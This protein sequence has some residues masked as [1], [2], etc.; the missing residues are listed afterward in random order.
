MIR[1]PETSCKAGPVAGL[2][3]SDDGMRERAT[4]V[5]VAPPPQQAT[6]QACERE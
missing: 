3:G 4:P 1:R 2:P 5:T 6:A